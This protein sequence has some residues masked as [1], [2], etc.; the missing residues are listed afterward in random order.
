[1]SGAHCVDRMA[2]EVSGKVSAAIYDL[3]ID[4]GANQSG[5]REAISNCACGRFAL[6]C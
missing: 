5:S 2:A 3:E 1:M 4:R 6:G